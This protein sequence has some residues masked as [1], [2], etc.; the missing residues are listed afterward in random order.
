[1]SLDTILSAQVNLSRIASTLDLAAGVIVPIRPVLDGS[2]ITTPLDS[3]APFPSVNKPL[4]ITSVAN[5]AGL[6]IYGA[7]TNPLPQSA[8]SPICLGAFLDPQ[9]T[10]IIVSSPFYSFP[11]SDGLIDA[12]VQLQELGTDYQ[13]RCSAWTFARNWVQNGG[14]AYVGKYLVGAT[15]PGNQGV[16]YCT[17]PGIVCHQDDIEI[18]VSTHV[19]LRNFPSSIKQSFFQFG[20]VSHPTRAQS[21][22]I[23]EIQSR[24]KAFLANGNP[25][26]HNVH[27]T[28][29]PASASNINLLLL[30]GSGEEPVGACT[31]DFWGKTALYDYQFF[32]QPSS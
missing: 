17:Q 20:T 19:T 13:W 25:N 29:T 15:Y 32:N 7:F 31:P 12:R 4:L 14:T 1:L 21:S 28:W 16:T 9:R 26:A 10:D 18:V 3:T 11:P 23:T 30:G 8:F 27:S 5:E 2:F 6:A 22:L 24:Y